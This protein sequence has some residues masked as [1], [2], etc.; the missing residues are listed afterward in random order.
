MMNND[1]LGGE[2]SEFGKKLCSLRRKC[3][4]SRYNLAR[5]SG[6]SEAYILRLET[7]ERRNPSRDVVIM[8]ALSL[9]RASDVFEVWDIDELLTSASYAPL[10]RRGQR[11]G[12]E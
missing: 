2:M 5:F 7:G 9:V 6:L 10:R 4:R 3:G 1:V 8:L 12:L 11:S